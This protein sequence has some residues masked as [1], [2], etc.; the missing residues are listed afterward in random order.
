MNPFFINAAELINSKQVPLCDFHIHTNFTDGKASVKDVFEK[1]ISIG[2]D[3]IAFTEHTEKWH[4]SD[5]E[6]FIRYYNEIDYNKNIFKD[7]IKAFI[8]IEAPAISFNGDIEATNE[9]ITKADFIL[10]AAHRYPSLGS[11]KVKELS[12]KE[13]VDMEYKTLMG[14]IQSKDVDAIAHIGATCSKYCG[15]FPKYLVREIICEAVKNHKII[16]VNPVYHKPLKKF[17]ELCA[18]EN[19]KIC[20]GSNAHGFNDIGLIVREIKKLFS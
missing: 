15:P 10:G 5:D 1:A 13:A 2:L 14:L 7:E 9:M 11:R 8:G 3:A 6:W 16:E 4:H 12:V 17:I 20:L 19:A 18:M